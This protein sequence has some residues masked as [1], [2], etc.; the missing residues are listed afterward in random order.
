MKL[1]TS[2]PEEI[3][4]YYPQNIQSKKYPMNL[5]ILNYA[6]KL[7]SNQAEQALNE[8][9]ENISAYKNK[10]SGAVSFK[11]RANEKIVAL[12]HWGRSGTGLLHSLL[13]GHPEVSTLPS[14]YLSEYFKQSN[15]ENL[16]SNGSHQIVDIHG[17]I[18]RPFR[19]RFNTSSA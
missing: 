5:S 15:W 10:T 6:M 16:I 14:V 17:K 11:P 12:V 7:G 13:D 2:S 8:A 9:L 19:R 1:R 18:R 3:V 4:T